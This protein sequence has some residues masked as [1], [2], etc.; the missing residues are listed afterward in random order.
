MSNWIVDAITEVFRR[1]EAR[2]S[3]TLVHTDHETEHVLLQAP[4]MKPELKV[5]QR[6]SPDI[7][8]EFLTVDGMVDYLKEYRIRVPRVFVSEHNIEA[9]LAYGQHRRFLARLL[10][11]P[12]AEY[13]AL[14][15][16]FQ[17]LGQRD[18]W[19]LL[20]GPLDGVLPPELLMGISKITA[21]AS[22]SS[23]SKIEVTGV[24]TNDRS[25]QVTVQFSNSTQA[26]IPLDWDARLPLWDCWRPRPED[27]E[28]E[29]VY[30]IKLR[31]VVEAAGGNGVQFRFV[32]KNLDD[33]FQTARQDVMAYLRDLLIHDVNTDNDLDGRIEVYEG[34]LQA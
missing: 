17:G 2:E 4:G 24:E 15:K 1:F 22:V 16:L 23:K 7:Q 6:P 19:E 31:M 32:P 10:F 25:T 30:A 28:G 21:T 3:D 34:K 5:F 33:T 14:H 18:L 9:D 26:Q 20:V 12:S 13:A 11:K 8:H 29:R 27:V